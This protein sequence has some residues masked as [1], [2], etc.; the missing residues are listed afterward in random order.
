MANKY[1]ALDTSTTANWLTSV[2]EALVDKFGSGV[3]INNKTTSVLTFTCP[4]I[5]EKTINLNSN[6]AQLGTVSGTTFT[7]QLSFFYSYSGNMFKHHDLVLGDNFFFLVGVG[8]STSY[9]EVCLIAKTVG[10]VSIFCGATSQSST[11]YNAN[12]RFTMYK[13]GVEVGYTDFLDFGRFIDSDSGVP[14]KMP[15]FIFNKNAEGDQLLR[16]ADGTSD[17]IDGLWMSAF[18]PG[19]TFVRAGGLFSATE[20]YT[21]DATIKLRTAIVAEFE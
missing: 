4:A 10:G 8:Y 11:T 2:A 19:T 1:Y 18:A 15:L 21:S 16:L 3:T 13:D 17:T 7:N 9:R 14:Y 6:Y 20:V 5:S 12:C